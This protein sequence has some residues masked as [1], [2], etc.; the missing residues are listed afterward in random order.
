MIAV[1]SVHSSWSRV[2]P[3]I[4]SYRASKSL[5]LYSFPL[6]SFRLGNF[7][8]I[9]SYIYFFSVH[10]FLEVSVTNPSLIKAETNLASGGV[11]L[12]TRLVS[13]S[14]SGATRYLPRFSESGH[15]TSTRHCCSILNNAAS[16]SKRPTLHVTPHSKPASNQPQVWRMMAPPTSR[17]TSWTFDAV[18]GRR[19]RRGT[20]SGYVTERAP[21]RH[22]HSHLFHTFWR[23]L[24]L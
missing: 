2:F 14:N 20:H 17:V 16:G 8:G 22:L 11:H 10:L 6:L 18:S 9:Y 4:P 23:R 1:N 12:W 24:L 3:R 21:P 19:A 7:C 15:C 13:W 5:T